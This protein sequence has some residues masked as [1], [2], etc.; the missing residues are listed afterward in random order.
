ML[1]QGTDTIS[2]PIPDDIWVP[3]DKLFLLEDTDP[4]DGVKILINASTVCVSIAAATLLV[5]IDRWGIAIA[6]RFSYFMLGSGP[7]KSQLF[8][9]A[10]K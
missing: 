5:P 10:A 3:G 2:V 7:E 8:A 1:G 4:T 9:Q 6:K